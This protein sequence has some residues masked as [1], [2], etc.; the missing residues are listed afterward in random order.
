MKFSRFASRLAVGGV[1]A[2]LATAGLVGV[3]STSASAAVVTTNYSCTGAGQTFTVPVTI[4]LALGI[5]TTG[6]AGFPV[7]AGL[8]SF[9]ST[10]T[11]PDPPAQTLKG[12]GVTGGKSDDFGAAFGDTVAKAPVTWGSGTDNLDMSITYQ[13]QGANSAFLLPAAGT[14]TVTMPKSFTLVT[15]GGPSPISATCTSASPTQ[16]GS[17]TLSKQNSKTKVNGPK[18]AKAGSVV[19]LKVKVT[20]DQLKAG[21]VVPSGK[22][23]VKDGKKKVGKGKLDKKGKAKIKIK[24][25]KAGSHKLVVFYKGDKYDVKSKSKALKLTVT[26]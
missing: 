8:L 14:Y 10:L 7:P 17:I 3:T 15:T 6:A 25:L 12:I 4:E 24:G 26:K 19:T 21:G 22:L 13:G 16:L 23:I 9:K 11:V 18:S 2:A 20:N 5:P 1:S